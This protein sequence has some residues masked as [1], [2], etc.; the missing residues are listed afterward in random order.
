MKITSL[1][2]EGITAASSPEN[3]TNSAPQ[4]GRSE[5]FLED[6]IDETT[7]SGSVASV[8]TPV[9]GMQ[10]RGKGSIF[11]GIK[12]SSK[13]PNSQAVKEGE[14]MS[15]FAALKDWR[16]WDVHVYNNFYR[17]KYADYGPRLY[18]VV[19][20]SPE[21]ARQVVINNPDYVLQDLL[22]RKL[23][24]GKK[25]LPRGSALPIEEK[26]VGK[27]EPGTITTMAFKK[28]LTPDGVQSFKFTNGKIVDGA[29]V[30][31]GEQLAEVDP[32]NFDS[33]VDY[34]NAVKKQGQQQFSGDWDV[35]DEIAS[36]EN[37]IKYTK[38]SALAHTLYQKIDQLKQ[39]A[40]IQDD[41]DE[42]E[43]EYDADIRARKGELEEA[44]WYPDR[45]YI[46]KSPRK[47]K[48]QVGNRV[49]DISVGS[50]KIYFKNG[51]SVGE[52]G[53]DPEASPGNGQYYMK[54]Y[55]S[56][57]DMGGYTTPLEAS[58]DLAH[59]VRQ[60]VDEGLGDTITKKAKQFSRYM[61]E[62]QSPHNAEVRSRAKNIANIRKQ[63]AKKSVFE[64]DPE[65]MREF[66]R[67]GG[68]KAGLDVMG[69]QVGWAAASHA[70]PGDTMKDAFQQLYYGGGSPFPFSEKAFKLAWVAYNKHHGPQVAMEQGSDNEPFNYDEW[71][72]STV[73]P[74]KPRGYKDAEAIGQQQ[75]EI[76]R[77]RKEK[78]KQVNEKSKSQAQFRT[79]AAVAHNP[80]FAKKV[81]ISQKVGKEFH[82]ADKG[83][84]YK[85][86]PKKVDEAEI[87]EDV[88]ANELY[89][90]LQIFKKGADKDIGSKAKDNEI[91][92][93]A[94][95][96][97]IINK[98]KQISNED[99]DPCWKD[100]KQI[101]MK[102]KNGKTVPNCVPKK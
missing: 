22:S 27:A 46:P 8:A 29:H 25:V 44:Q 102:K 94:K 7:S 6:Q 53:I 84:D 99:K 45:E 5:K 88:L 36:L 55:L 14:S 79:M 66:E 12:T 32:H 19:A 68:Y 75:K 58:K 82:K 47:R 61:T 18:S 101:G 63:E 13:F 78:E 30:Q 95:D 1:L 98:V 92:S 73:K 74:R 41:E 62:P 67:S 23:V 65:A 81:G 100:Y 2:Q 57:K 11:S 35:Y 64:K 60:E 76:D 26:R 9:G 93:K 72:A 77:E 17:G 83:V 51:K 89:K 91:S 42:Y 21:E 52:V 96:K 28:M 71:K 4:M 24:S 34:Y 86:L 50:P 3:A 20:S 90:D 39:Q 54:H 59:L 43:K 87:A 38:S 97:E 56:G 48:P 49:S 33:D 69:W 85:S 31:G 40:G 70:K 37:Q 10:R 80:E 15:T 16:V